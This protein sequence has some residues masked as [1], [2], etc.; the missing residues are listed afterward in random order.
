MAQPSHTMYTQVFEFKRF[1]KTDEGTL[2]LLN[3]YTQHIQQH[4]E[5]GTAARDEQCKLLMVFISGHLQVGKRNS[6]VMVSTM[7]LLEPPN[8]ASGRR[9]ISLTRSGTPSCSRQLKH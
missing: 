3:Y 5:T 6:S 7:C 4:R 9:Q 1:E 2:R 8:S